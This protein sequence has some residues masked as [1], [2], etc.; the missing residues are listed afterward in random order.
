[1]Y[2]KETWGNNIWFLFHTIAYKIKEDEF[3]N[4]KQD[5]ITLVKLICTNLPCPECSTDA[6]ELIN[7]VNFNNINTKQE[8]K[9]LIFNFH[10]YVNKKL[11]K[12]LFDENDL[13][14]KYS[15]ANIHVLYKNFNIIFSANSN[16]PQL[17]SQ[18][19]HRKHNLPKI[20]TILNKLLFKL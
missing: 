3:I 14:D 19:F 12:P 15:K 9:L 18:S 11:K 10:N 4:C 8:F 20:Q 16:I 17:M 7:K 1:M 2:N 13:D 5:L 6:T